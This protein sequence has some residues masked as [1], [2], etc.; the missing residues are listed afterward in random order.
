M[1]AA[2]VLLGG[3]DS[4]SRGACDLGEFRK[5]NRF[6]EQ[7]CDGHLRFVTEGSQCVSSRSEVSGVGFQ[8]LSLRGV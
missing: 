4:W 8:A 5:R 3:R 7:V 6:E 1:V 2:V